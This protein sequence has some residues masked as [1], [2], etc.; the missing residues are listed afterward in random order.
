MKRVEQAE[1]SPGPFV[2]EVELGLDRGK[3]DTL[4]AATKRLSA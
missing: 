3:A 2:I 4:S 1:R